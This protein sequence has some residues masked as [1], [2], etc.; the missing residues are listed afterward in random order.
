MASYELSPVALEDI[1]QIQEF[2]ARDN[3]GAAEQL[4]EQVFRAF[5]HLPEWPRS[6]HTRVDLTPRKVLFWPV[7]SCLVVYC[8]GLKSSEVQIVAVLHGARDLLK[9]LEER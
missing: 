2:I 7:G 6:G 4:V 5:E 8:E 3:V 9:I 1:L